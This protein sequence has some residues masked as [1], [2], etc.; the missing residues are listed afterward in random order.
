[1]PTAAMAESS[2]QLEIR[3]STRPRPSG[4][5]SNEFSA[6][7]TRKPSTKPGMSGGRLPPVT[8]PRG[9]Q[10]A[11]TTTTGA[12]QETRMSLTSVEV[13][14]AVSEIEKPAPTTCATSCTVPP[15]KAP[16][17]RSSKPSDRVRIG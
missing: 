12:R 17:V 11:I 2:A 1:M 9:C 14:P 15:M 4:I 10:S 6:A 13:S 8:A 7:S 3:A 16:A 5:S